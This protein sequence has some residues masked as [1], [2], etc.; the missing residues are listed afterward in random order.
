MRKFGLWYWL[1]PLLLFVILLVVT[2]LENSFNGFV[3]TLNWWRWIFV[4]LGALFFG[5]VFFLLVGRGI[6]GV[7]EGK[8]YWTR[9]ECDGIIRREMAR[10]HCVRVKNF[11][12]LSSSFG[13][14]GNFGESGQ[15]M[16]YHGLLKTDR[17]L[18]QYVVFAMVMEKG[19]EDRCSYEFRPMNIGEVK[20]ERIRLDMVNELADS[21][22]KKDV[23]E[24]SRVDPFTG[25]TVTERQTFKKKDEKDEDDEE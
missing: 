6:V 16:I 24:R 5:V 14:V 23:F 8:S 25:H 9:A 12:D 4:P 19:K 15:T 13:R 22:E 18:P 7:V 20:L 21:P 1:L 10:V 17:A 11:S 2:V 3:W